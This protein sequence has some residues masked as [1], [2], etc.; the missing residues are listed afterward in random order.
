MIEAGWTALRNA[1]KF[2]R[3]STIYVS[4]AE[5]HAQSIALCHPLCANAG[6]KVECRTSQLGEHAGSG[7]FLNGDVGVNNVVALFP[8]IYSPGLPLYVDP[9]LLLDGVNDAA[10]IYEM[11]YRERIKLEESDETEL[12]R[13]NLKSCGGGL[14][15][16]GSTGTAHPEL[17]RRMT[18]NPFA[19]GHKINHPPAGGV[20]VSVWVYVSTGIWVYESMEVWEWSVW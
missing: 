19:L 12:Y 18:V 9:E 2:S 17:A 6:H 5:V 15:P 3:V 10:A 4:E 8:G 11:Q 1:L 7:V 20:P 16:G 13:I 14:D